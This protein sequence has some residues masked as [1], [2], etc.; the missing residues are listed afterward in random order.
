MTTFNAFN[1]TTFLENWVSLVNHSLERQLEAYK[2]L[3]NNFMC[4]F[5]SMIEWIKLN[6]SYDIVFSLLL[7]I[8]FEKIKN[9]NLFSLIHGT[10]RELY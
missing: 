1:F 3:V 7:K 2:N 10:E 5:L 9:I 6:S 8:K 4:V